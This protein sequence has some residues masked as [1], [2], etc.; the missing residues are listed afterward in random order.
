[1]SLDIQTR[2]NNL[3][4]YNVKEAQGGT[5]DC[6]TVVKYILK[7]KMQIHSCDNFEYEAVFRMGKPSVARGNTKPRPLMLRFIRYKDRELVLMSAKMLKGSGIH[8]SEDYP[9][10]IAETTVAG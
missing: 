8:L 3:L 9:K 2:R 4:L 6:E 7:D 5:E 10:I 1:M